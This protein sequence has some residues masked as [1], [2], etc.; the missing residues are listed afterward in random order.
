MPAVIACCVLFA[1]NLMARIALVHL[2]MFKMNVLCSVGPFTA[3][4]PKMGG[5]AP[6][7]TVRLPG[8]C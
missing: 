7:E 1:K 8:G 3:L 6:W 2:D 5:S 4:V